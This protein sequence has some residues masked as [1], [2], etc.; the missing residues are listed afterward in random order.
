MLTTEIQE[1][2]RALGFIQVGNVDGD[3]GPRTIAAVKDFQI[4]WTYENLAVD[5]KVGP[6]TENALR[7]C[8][9]RNGLLSDHFT[10]IEFRSKGDGTLKVHR[11]LI[12]GLEKYRARLGA[13]VS[14]VSGYRDPAYN[15]KI[16]GA[17]SS[18]HLYGTAADIPARLSW[19]A[20]KA[21]ACF[22]GIGYDRATGFV[23]HVDTRHASSNNTTGGTPSNPTVW[24]Y[25]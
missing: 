4:A 22:S 6:R 3:Y 1:Y 25:G 23:R 8:R 21:L 10:T 20:V 5:G 17:T 12:R 18:Q 14:I 9:A 24:V 19:R 2:L 15:K 16:G 11:E 13:G 7:T